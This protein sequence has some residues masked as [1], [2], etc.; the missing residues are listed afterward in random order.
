MPALFSSRSL[1]IRMI[2]GISLWRSGMTVLATGR[3]VHLLMTT[4]TVPVIGRLQARRINME[5]VDVRRFTV[6]MFRR[7]CIDSMTS[8]ASNLCGLIT[9]SMASYTTIVG[10]PGTG[11]MV[12]AG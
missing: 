10:S 5:L 8:T 7:E 11:C 12:M 2:E 9:V 4:D 6:D 3:P 1:R